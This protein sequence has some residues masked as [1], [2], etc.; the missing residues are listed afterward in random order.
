MAKRFFHAT[1]MEPRSCI[2]NPGFLDDPQARWA[3]MLFVATAGRA[4]FAVESAQRYA[5]IIQKKKKASGL[6][7]DFPSDPRYLN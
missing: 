7:R 1:E 2:Q 5:G 3:V 4:T 6:S